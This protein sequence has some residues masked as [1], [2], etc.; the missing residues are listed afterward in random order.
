MREL[1]V[2]KIVQATN[3]D[4]SL[5]SAL[6]HAQKIITLVREAEETMAKARDDFDNACRAF[7]LKMNEY[8]SRCH[9]T[10]KTYHVQQGYDPLE[11]D[12]YWSECDIC[13]KKVKDE[14]DPSRR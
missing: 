13:G 7:G 2:E 4:E 6:I 1:P 12:R 8:Q 5:A 10:A 9:H 3:G 14:C 11:A